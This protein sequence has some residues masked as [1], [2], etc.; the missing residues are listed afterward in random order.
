TSSSSVFAS[1]WLLRWMG[2]GEK[3]Y[4]NELEF[5]R[6]VVR[7][8]LLYRQSGYMNAVVDTVVRREA[9]DVHVLF[10]IY[11]GE[12]VRLTRLSLVGLD[13]LLDVVALKRTLPLQEGAPFNR[14]L[15][16][17]SADTI[18][19]RTRGDHG[20]RTG[21][22]RDRAEDALGAPV[23][24]VPAR[25]GVPEPA[26]SVRHG[27][28]PVRERRARRLR[29]PPR[30]FHGDGA[31]AGRGGAAPPGARGRRVRQPRLLPRAKRLDGV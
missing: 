24:P 12:P 18:A 21:G 17:A 9:G 29:A 20:P 14:M 11:E 30:G 2:L 8:L 5:R 22:H 28:V 10:R 27:G 31:R 13:S 16:Q 3:R 6:D 7:L 19:D 25:P 15:F 4:F 1:V 26:R 23:R